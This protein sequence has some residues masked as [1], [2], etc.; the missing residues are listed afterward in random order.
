MKAFQITVVRQFYSCKQRLSEIFTRSF[1]NLK[2]NK[3]KDLKK[4]TFF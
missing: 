3:I 2:K 4:F 1:F